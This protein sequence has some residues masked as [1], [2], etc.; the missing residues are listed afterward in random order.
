M[1]VFLG[2]GK[3]ISENKI[4]V[5]DNVLEFA[6]AV[7]ATGG[8]PSVPPIPGVD[9]IEYLTNQSL[10]NLTE[11]PAKMAVI[12]SG[13]IGCEIA[14]A[15]ALFGSHVIVLN[16]S[17]RI[18]GKEDHEAAQ[19]VR[20]SMESCGVH[21]MLGVSYTSIGY[22]DPT[23]GKAGGIKIVIEHA[24]EKKVEELIVDDVLIATGRKPNVEN[25]G[26]EK[27]G[28]K[29]D[30]YRGI[31]VNDYLQTSNNNVYAVGDCCTRYQ[32]THMADAMARMVIRNALFFGRAKCSDL[33]IPWCTYTF[34]EVAHVGLYE[35]DLQTRRIDYDVIKVDL[36]H[37]D[38]AI[39]EDETRGFVKMLIKKGSDQILGCTIVSENAGDQINEV[40]LAIQTNT[41]LGFFAGVIHPYPTIG[42]A[43]KAAGDA[44]N[45][46]RL[47]P[48][49]KALLRRILSARR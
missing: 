17:D 30:V 1:D 24:K 33:V 40:T 35:G 6:R 41:G 12:G 23:K 10:W 32:F 4:K 29:F 15:F 7:I 25:M 48:V 19:V 20:E 31:E 44:Y 14:Q 26:L 42:E 9:T 46:T 8:Q 2:R 3:F 38:R 37:N 13:P 28:V 21:F 5:G 18:L 39:C 43:V 36:D 34:P 49:S 47:T 27:A 11:L 45:R 16:R 22:V